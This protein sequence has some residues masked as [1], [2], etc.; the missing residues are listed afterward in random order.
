MRA[1]VLSGGGSKGAFTAGVVRHLLREMQFDLAVGTSTGALVTGPALLNDADYCANIYSSV[2]DEDIFQN[3]LIGEIATVVDRFV[4]FISGPI[5][6]NLQPLR[7]LLDDYYLRDGKLDDLLDSGKEMVV[8]AVNVRTGC[9]QF[10]SSRQIENDEFGD[11]RISRETFISAIVASCS[12]PFFVKPVMIFEHEKNHPNRNDLFYDGG[13]KEFLPVEYAVTS[14]ATEIWAVSTHP[15]QPVTTLWGDTTSPD[16]VSFLDAL[17][18]TI[19]ALLDEVAR[20][21]RFRADVYYKWTKIKM[22]IEDRAPELLNDETVKCFLYGQTLPEL[23][24]IHPTEHL[25]TSLKFE[26]AVMWEYELIGERRAEYM[27]RNRLTKMNDQT[28]R[29]WGFHTTA[30]PA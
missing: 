7:R 20:G 2:Q 22:L 25:A 3:S 24:L 13:V 21:D 1:L 27:I 16:N 19:G 9:V 29:P 10:I 26:P 11:R 4:D 8:S 23:H 28:L 6:A 15:L 5:D 30:E 12:E 14:G 18:W 17:R